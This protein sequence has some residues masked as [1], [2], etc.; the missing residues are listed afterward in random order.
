M[1]QRIVGRTG[2]SRNATSNDTKSNEWQEELP[3]GPFGKNIATLKRLADTGNADAAYALAKGFRACEFFVPLKNNAEVAKRAQDSICNAGEA[4]IVGSIIS[5]NHAGLNGGGLFNLNGTLKLINSTVSGNQSAND[6][7]GVY[8]GSGEIDLF[9]VT[10]TG[11]IANADQSGSAIGGGVDNVSGATLNFIN[12][13]LTG[14]LVLTDSAFSLLSDCAGTITSQG[15]SIVSYLYLDTCTVLGS[16]STYQPDLGPLQYNGGP[17]MT[18]ALLSGNTGAGNPI[19]GGNPSGCT[20][21]LGATLATDQRELPRT[22]GSACDMGA[23][24]VQPDLI[25]KNGFQA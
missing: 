1:W 22:I 18:H 24:E 20:D 3:L 9:N 25:F 4:M 16:Y 19:D 14:N 7:G 21:N 17:T 12:S 11:N 6:G 15:Y 5:G 8:N 10:V 13:I 2:P 23:Y